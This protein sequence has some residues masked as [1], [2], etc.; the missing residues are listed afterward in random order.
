[1]SE[2]KNETYLGDGVYAEYDGFH[3]TL[4]GNAYFQDNVIYLDANAL[5]EFLR[6]LERVKGVK[7]T[8]ER[9]KE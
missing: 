4:K 9:R 6:Y 1:M 8:V 2:N 5:S 7:I 3:V